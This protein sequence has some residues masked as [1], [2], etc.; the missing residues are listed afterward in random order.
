MF[1]GPSR[2][3]PW[4]SWLYVV[5]WSLMIYGTMPLARVIQEF[6]AQHWGRDLFADVVLVTVAIVLI[7]ACYHVIRHLRRCGFR[8]QCLGFDNGQRSMDAEK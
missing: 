8:V 5:S 4:V 3:R 6:V 2:E 7:A 1:E